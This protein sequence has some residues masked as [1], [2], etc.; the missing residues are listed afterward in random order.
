MHIN[1]LCVFP[2]LSIVE[3]KK[4]QKHFLRLSV[5]DNLELL[6]EENSTNSDVHPDSSLQARSVTEAE[7]DFS[8]EDP[9]TKTNEK[10]EGLEKMDHLIINNIKQKSKK[11]EKVLQKTEDTIKLAYTAFTYHDA[12]SFETSVFDLKSKNSE[13]PGVILDKKATAGSEMEQLE[14]NI[15]SSRMYIGDVS[16]VRQKEQSQHIIPN[17]SLYTLDT[18][19]QQNL[20]LSE[21][22]ENENK[23]DS[24][25]KVC[26]E[27]KSED[28]SQ[29]EDKNGKSIFFIGKKMVQNLIKWSFDDYEVSSSTNY[30][31]RLSKRLTE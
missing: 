25:S 28:E 13:L 20:M 29:N 8:A 15:E 30:L 17:S 10:I 9:Q 6:R 24:K 19:P 3:W 12:S 22:K 11:E 26:S 14:K 7:N 21:L 1:F 2:F 23:N 31:H 27:K 5:K 18:S 4:F 16:P